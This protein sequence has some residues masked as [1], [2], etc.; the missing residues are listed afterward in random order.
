MTTDKK[1]R[2][3]KADQPIPFRPSELLTAIKKIA[4]L[5]TEL[6]S[7]RADHD[8][9]MAAI[10]SMDDGYHDTDLKIA[11]LRS[12]YVHL[13]ARLDT[14]TTPNEDAI[15]AVVARQVNNLVERHALRRQQKG[16]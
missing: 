1:P 7:L 10:A 3:K 5:E 4:S 6:A 9:A 12:G 14:V 13:S 8:C 16:A 2:V 11:A 15:A